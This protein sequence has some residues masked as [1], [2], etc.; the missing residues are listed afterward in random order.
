MVRCSKVMR[1]CVFSA[2]LDAP[3]GLRGNRGRRGSDE[4]MVPLKIDSGCRRCVALVHV[5]GFGAID[6][7]AE[8]FGPAVV[9]AG[10]HLGLALVDQREVEVGDDRALA[11]T[12]RLAEQFALR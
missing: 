7:Q 5:R 11:G 10:V 9:S 2:A 4:S 3:A 6:Q 12:Q 8:Q 1:S